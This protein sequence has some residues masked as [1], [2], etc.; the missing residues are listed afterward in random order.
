MSRKLETNRVSL[1]TL[2]RAYASVSN[3]RYAVR[4]LFVSTNG[5]DY[6]MTQTGLS[7]ESEHSDSFRRV[8]REYCSEWRLVTRQ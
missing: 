8:S 6:W 5:G 4:Q 2:P 7:V 3:S 1:A